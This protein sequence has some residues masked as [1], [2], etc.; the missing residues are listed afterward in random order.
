[1]MFVDYGTIS[2]P[3]TIILNE[4]LAVAYSGRRKDVFTIESMKQLEEMMD[5]ILN[6]DMML[7]F[8]QSLINESLRQEMKEIS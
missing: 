5:T 3:V 1:M 2:Y 8:I 6:S 4:D 7:S